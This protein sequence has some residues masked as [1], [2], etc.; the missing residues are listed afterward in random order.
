M[1]LNLVKSPPKVPSSSVASP[2]RG[3]LDEARPELR[4][5]TRMTEEIRL[6]VRQVAQSLEEVQALAVTLPRSSTRFEGLFQL[7]DNLALLVSKLKQVQTWHAELHRSDH[8]LSINNVLFAEISL[9]LLFPYLHRLL[10][11]AEREPTTPPWTPDLL[12]AEDRRSSLHY[13]HI[14]PTYTTKY[15]GPTLASILMAVERNRAWSCF[16][17]SQPSARQCGEAKVLA[18]KFFGIILCIDMII[19]PVVTE[20]HDLILERAVGQPCELEVP[21]VQTTACL[22]HRRD[23]EAHL[24]NFTSKILMANAIVERGFYQTSR[25]AMALHW[26]AAGCWLAQPCN[27]V[28]AEHRGDLCYTGTRE[29]IKEKLFFAQFVWNLPET[30]LVRNFYKLGLPSIKVDY[31]F[32]V[33]P[34][35]VAMEG[36]EEPV[37]ARVVSNRRLAR[38]PDTP[39]RA[40]ALCF[41]WQSRQ[42]NSAGRT[43]LPGLQ[44]SAGAAGGLCRN[45]DVLMVHFHG[46]GFISMSSFSHENY[47]RHWARDVGL[48]VVS[49]DYRLAP[50]HKFPVPFND[51][52][53]TY[54]YCL[55][56]ATEQLGFEPRKIILAGD[57]AG[58]NLACAFGRAAR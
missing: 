14:D 16:P 6:S 55:D 48:N 7:R 34:S 9:L 26:A 52:Y 42:V 19:D 10:S 53:R 23:A 3:G 32:F 51:A 58:G 56:A 13:K 45:A 20:E 18:T 40:K 15:D 44:A 2:K 39:T 17:S 38:L 4:A 50:A 25:L 54:R 29:E 30:A 49:A 37:K 24:R 8:A 1:F 47:T 36:G 12:P 41:D 57:S 31:E 43:L 11:R 5:A 46:G 22:Y 27:R 28:E 21:G 33:P 35:P